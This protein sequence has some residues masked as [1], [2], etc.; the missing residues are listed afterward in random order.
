MGWERSVPIGGKVTIQGLKARADL[1]GEIG[2]VI[3]HLHDDGR[4]GVRVLS[5]GQEVAIKPVN[6]EL[7]PGESIRPVQFH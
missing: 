4:I 7:C 1:N 2:Q 6:A 5:S 3:S